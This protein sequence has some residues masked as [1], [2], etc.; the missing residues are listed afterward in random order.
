MILTDL[1]A[2]QNQVIIIKCTT[3]SLQIEGQL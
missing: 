1:L 2:R 3:I